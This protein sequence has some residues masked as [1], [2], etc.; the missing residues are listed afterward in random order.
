[1]RRFFPIGLFIVLVTIVLCGCDKIKSAL[2]F[3]KSGFPVIE[4]PA[5]FT[6][7]IQRKD[8]VVFVEYSDSLS[9]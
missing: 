7:T 3:K 1:M 2:I 5:L 6:G 4:A 9:M 8:C